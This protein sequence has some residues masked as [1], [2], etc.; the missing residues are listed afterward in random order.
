MYG[1]A[2]DEKKQI[3]A[4]LEFAKAEEKL[5]ELLPAAEALKDAAFLTN[6]TKQAIELI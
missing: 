4:L 3:H 2:G 5:N 1:K 6:D